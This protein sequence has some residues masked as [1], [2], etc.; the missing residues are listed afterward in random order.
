MHL[1]GLGIPAELPYWD[2]SANLFPAMILL[3][4]SSSVIQSLSIFL[5]DP[6]KASLPFLDEKAQI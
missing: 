2:D 3:V 4:L 5:E 6:A 1:S